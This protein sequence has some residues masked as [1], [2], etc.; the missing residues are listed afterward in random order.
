MIYSS[1]YN[2]NLFGAATLSAQQ[3]FDPRDRKKYSLEETTFR[4]FLVWSIR[5]LFHAIMVMKV[6]GLENFP[7]GG[8]VIVAANHNTNFDVFPAQLSLPRSIFFMG[9]AELFK[10]P[11]E[12]FLRNLGA[13]P[14]N[15]GEK[16]EWAIRYARKVLAHGQT[17]GMFPEGTRSKGRGLNVAKTGAARMAIELNCPIIP[18][19]VIGSDQFFKRFPRRSHVTVKLLPPILP[20]P[21]DTP[22]SLT[23]RLMFALAAGLPE[24][25]RGVYAKAPRGFGR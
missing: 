20:N 1:K 19:A 25:M 3:D 13:F 2:R 11:L 6:E 5:N 9:K 21:H 17:L 23:D 24:E 16:D 10:T 18:M 15:R 22:L 14:V 8:A 4:R 12:P 7:L